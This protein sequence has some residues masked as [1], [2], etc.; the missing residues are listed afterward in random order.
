MLDQEL[1]LFHDTA[2]LLAITDLMCPLP[3]PEILWMSR[4]SEQW[5][6][7]MQSLHNCTVN[8]NPQLLSTSSAA[9]SLH[10]LFQDFLQDNLLRR[11]PNL[12]PQQLRLILHPLQALICH[13]RQMVSC[14]SDVFDP[15]HTGTSAMTKASVMHR[16]D[17]TQALLQK[18]YDI[19]LTY[20]KANPACSI[21]RC[22]LVIYHLLYLNTVT[23]L[24]ETE[25]FARRE[26]LG[27]LSWELPLRHGRCIFHR[28][29]AI[30]HCGQVFRLLH[31]M[32]N[33]RRPA[34]WAAAMYRAAL[35]LW[36]DSISRMDQH[37]SLQQQQQGLAPVMIDR[38]P[39]EDPAVMAL[40]WGG[41]G[42]SSGGVGVPVLVCPD[43]TTVGLDKPAKIL[44][45]AVKH[46]E[47]CFSSRIGDGIKR[48]LVTRGNNWNLAAMGVGVSPGGS[49]GR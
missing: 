35:V 38:L 43:G 49:S 46:I 33:D 14:F 16:L 3:A 10:E 29:K 12:S 24:P 40:A 36:T 45:Y 15:S 1:S 30:A 39:L 34:W 7:T 48:K 25:R 18:W 32:P 4:N 23:S 21:T 6:T 28:P 13:L 8:V 9:P 22:N 26:G 27:N 17:E 11:H 31:L 44:G 2:P 5:F 42:S 19:T 47:T 20:L 41:G 37:H